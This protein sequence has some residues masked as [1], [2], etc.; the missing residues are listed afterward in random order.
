MKFCEAERHNKRNT[1]RW[2]LQVV[3]AYGAVCGSQVIVHTLPKA[4]QAGGMGGGAALGA[5]WG[6]QQQAAWTGGVLA[7]ALARSLLQGNR[8]E[9]IW[10]SVKNAC[11]RESTW[12]KMAFLSHFEVTWRSRSPRGWP[13]SIPW[14]TPGDSSLD[15]AIRSLHGTFSTRS[16]TQE[17]SPQGLLHTSNVIFPYFLGEHH[18]QNI[19]SYYVWYRICKGDNSEEIRGVIMA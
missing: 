17:W 16:K 5:G 1:V 14:C 10:T 19:I 11:R 3:V 18:A 8:P 2:Y 7:G 13:G 9:G 12:C 4:L 15:P 6:F